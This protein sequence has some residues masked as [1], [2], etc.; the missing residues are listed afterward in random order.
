M[1]LRRNILLFHQGALG[2][3]I[4]TWPIALALAR[5]HPQS[6]LFYVTHA[7]KGKLAEKALGVESADAETGWHTLFGDA[8]GSLPDGPGKLLAG[9]HSVIGF[10]S[11]PN[12]PWASNVKRLAPDA[13]VLRIDPRPPDD[14]TAHAT[15][16]QLEQLRAWPAAHAAAVQIHRSIQTRGIGVSRS[17][18]ARDVIIHPGSGSPA[19]NWPV[20]HFLEL[21]KRLRAAGRSVRVLLGDVEQEK[22]DP[23]V[24][25]RLSAG[26]PV[27]RPAN[28]VDL[29]AELSRAGA[30]VGNDSGPAHLAGIAGAPTLTLFGPSD[31]VRWK[32]LGPDVRTLR[33]EPLGALGVDEVFAALQ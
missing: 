25:A 2:D 27:G 24:A 8:P 4:L 31:P 20:Q 12:G 9:A 23:D 16:F 33:R 13:N 5:I 3:F 11:D 29:F 26:A 14:W 30:F 28:Y 10:V 32:P 22:W 17:T 7:Q 1:A 21:I 6:R 18:E 19:K 15:D